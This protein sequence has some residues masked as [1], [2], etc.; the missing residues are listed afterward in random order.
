MGLQR[1]RQN[2][3][4]EKH[5]RHTYICICG[6]RGYYLSEMSHIRERKTPYDFTYMGNLT[7]KTSNKTNKANRHRYREP[8]GSLPEG[9]G[10]VGGAK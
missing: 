8:T 5:Q 2:L 9:R 3:A 6:I 1:V 4:T 10:G 7:N